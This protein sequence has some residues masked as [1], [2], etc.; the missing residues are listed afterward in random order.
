M[1]LVINKEKLYMEKGGEERGL[2][3]NGIDFCFIKW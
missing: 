3:G 1:K 2:D